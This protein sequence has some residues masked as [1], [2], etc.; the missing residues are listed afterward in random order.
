MEEGEW[1]WRRQERQTAKR[2]DG[3]TDERQRWARWSGSPG[4]RPS[5]CQ[6]CSPAVPSPAVVEEETF[7]LLE[8][9]IGSNCAIDERLGIL[10]VF[11]EVIWPSNGLKF[12]I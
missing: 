6:D 9:D 10:L 7:V 1:R 4:R 5:S 8:R 11:G 2:A 3:W 12:Q